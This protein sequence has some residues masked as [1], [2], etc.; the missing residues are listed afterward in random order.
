MHCQGSIIDNYYQSEAMPRYN[1]KIMHCL[2]SV[3]LE[4]ILAVLKTSQNLCHWS[5]IHDRGKNLSINAPTPNEQAV[6]TV[7]RSL[8][9]NGIAESD[10]LLEY[11]SSLKATRN[12]IL[13]MLTSLQCFG[14]CTEYS[15]LSS[16]GCGAD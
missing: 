8:G 11:I 2:D 16:D 7:N 3:E 5:T 6:H 9:G 1:V 10:N 14:H 13:H 15:V 4:N 12:S